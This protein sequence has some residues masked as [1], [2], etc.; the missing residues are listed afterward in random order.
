MNAAPE[1]DQTVALFPCTSAYRTR[2]PI[3][4]YIWNADHQY[5]AS[6]IMAPA[7]CQCRRRVATVLV[8]TRS[9]SG[10]VFC[11]YSSIAS[12][13]RR[14]L[15]EERTDAFSA[16]AARIAAHS[17]SARRRRLPFRR[18]SRRDISD[19]IRSFVDRQRG[20][21]SR[22]A[23]GSRDPLKHSWRHAD[24]LRICERGSEFVRQIESR[25]R[26]P[27]TLYSRGFFGFTS[28]ATLGIPLLSAGRDLR[29]ERLAAH[30][31]RV[32][33]AFRGIAE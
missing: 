6:K 23:G 11:R 21:S 7:L 3:I 9:V 29:A 15:S 5:V 8:P 4:P 27:T 16:R 32:R 17:V 22:P 10:F 31:R 1:P 2:G 30:Q 33:H 13:P 19:L 18:S 26:V 12:G 20:S 24:V 14:E 28:G 25:N